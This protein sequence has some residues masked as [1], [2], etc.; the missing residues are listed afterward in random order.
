MPKK[1]KPAP[2]KKPSRKVPPD[3]PRVKHPPRLSPSEVLARTSDDMATR[4]ARKTGGAARIA[5]D[6]GLPLVERRKA[7]LLLA[8]I[9]YVTDR[10]QR[11]LQ[12]LYERDDRPYAELWPKFKQFE[13]V[14]TRE[15]WNTERD[16][17]WTEAQHIVQKRIQRADVEALLR[18]TKRM[19]D[20][21]DSLMEYVEPQ[22]TPDGQIERHPDFLPDNVT[23]HP[24]RGRPVLPLEVPSL[25][26]FVTV[27]LKLHDKLN[28]QR[29][30][31]S[32]R[33]VQTDDDAVKAASKHDES[34]TMND[35]VVD[36]FTKAMLAQG[37]G[38]GDFEVGDLPEI[39]NIGDEEVNDGFG[40]P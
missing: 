30:M 7:A 25:D 36:A 2:R 32:G 16:S 5:A 27:L 20:A 17:H 3:V 40:E 24:Y 1:K 8:K 29:A 21:F 12:W 33:P 28:S 34:I 14:A 4:A 26:K 10:E 11:T 39:T 18:D 23:P 6:R 22:R 31:I 37:K 15:Q 38:M 9:E 35:A 19:G 13:A